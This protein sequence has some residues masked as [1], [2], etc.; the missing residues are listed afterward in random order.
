MLSV[1]PY[2]VFFLQQ[3]LQSFCHE[4]TTFITVILIAYY[5][6]IST[7]RYTYLTTPN[8]I[9]KWHTYSISGFITIHRIQNKALVFTAESIAIFSRLSHLIQLS[10]NG[11]YLLLSDSFSFLYFSYT[12]MQSKLKLCFC[13]VKKINFRLTKFLSH[14][15][16][17]LSFL[18]KKSVKK[19]YC[20]EIKF[21]LI[22]KLHP[23]T[24]IKTQI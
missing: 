3:N 7:L 12:N 8:S 22:P 6:N 2:Q 21:D 10:S 18:F 16:C 5:L 4:T 1:Q 24:E 13:N 19:V 9:T 23:I 17:I 15:E 20:Y 11:E 14:W